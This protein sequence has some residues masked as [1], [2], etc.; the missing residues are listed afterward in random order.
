MPVMYNVKIGICE[1]N[2]VYKLV[3]HEKKEKN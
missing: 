1:K 2:I 3:L